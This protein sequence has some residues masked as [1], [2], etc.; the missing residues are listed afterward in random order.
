MT[1]ELT[2]FF[3]EGMSL[4]AWDDA[5]MLERELALYRRLHA[6]GIQVT[7]VTYGRRMERDYANGLGGMRLVHNRWKLSRDLYRWWLMNRYRGGGRGWIA[8]S[9]QVQGAEV[10]LAAAQHG[11][12]FV[13]RCGYLH[14]EFI[15]K[16]Y[17]TGSPQAV[18]A[19][20]LEARVFREA[21]RVVVTS[22]AMKET[23]LAR[24]GLPAEKMRVI[25]NYVDTELFRPGEAGRQGQQVCFIG[26]LEEQKN[27]FALL[28][29]M[30]GLEA[31]LVLAGEGSLRAALEARAAEL[32][33]RGRFLGAVP[34]A[35][36]P[37]LLNESAV[38]VLPSLYEGHPKTL[39]EA[40]ACGAAVVGTDVQGIREIVRDGENGLL[41]APTAGSL[42]AALTRLLADDGLRQRLGA[43]ARAYAVAHFSL[44]EVVKLELALYE[45]LVGDAA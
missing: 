14:S 8:K 7:L 1:T 24:Y 37:A 38:Y 22:E 5:G 33:V 6:A 10:A 42:R 43:A 35:A 28:E 31:E 26:R 17:G 9:N 23:V 20:V 15:E 29:A 45:E 2:L 11:G 19:G 3:T 27:L 36:L 44:D 12:H 41:C 21:K 16:E 25:P 40:M 30:A 34:N 13:A 18:D 4:K 39:I 32:G